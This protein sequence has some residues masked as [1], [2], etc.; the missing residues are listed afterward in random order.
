MAGLVVGLWAGQSGAAR[1]DNGPLSICPPGPERHCRVLLR[2]GFPLTLP[3]VM[4][5]NGSGDSATGHL[6][7]GSPDAGAGARKVTG[8]GGARPWLIAAAPRALARPIGSHRP[9]GAAGN[10]LAPLA[11]DTP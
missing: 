9:V 2:D 3:S 11:A 6:D 4:G 1:G 10:G 7:T 8:L 5:P